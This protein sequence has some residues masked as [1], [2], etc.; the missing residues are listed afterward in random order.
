MSV[1]FNVNENLS[2]SWTSSEDTYDD[3]SNTKGGTEIADVTVDA[4][5]IQVAYSMGAMSI[6]AYNIETD[7][8]GY[9]NDAEKTSVTEIALGLAF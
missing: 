3:Q 2:I 6:K 1:A 8:P 4:T 9:D 7:N 5:A